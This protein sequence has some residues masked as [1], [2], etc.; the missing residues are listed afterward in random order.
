SRLDCGGGPPP[1]PTMGRRPT[2]ARRRRPTRNLTRHAGRGV[3]LVD[4]GPTL[5]FDPR[6]TGG[7]LRRKIDRGPPTGPAFLPASRRTAEAAPGYRG[8]VHRSREVETA[9]T[10]SPTR[11]SPQ[12]VGVQ[13]RGSS[14][15]G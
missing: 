9:P 1:P 13:A 7:W 10:P 4:R 8:A 2:L 3:E 5:P 6:R 14:A 11:R 12:R 15:D